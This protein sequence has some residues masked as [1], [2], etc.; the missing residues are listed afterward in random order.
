MDNEAELLQAGV[1]FR[2]NKRGEASARGE[3]NWNED[4]STEML[5]DHVDTP[6]PVTILDCKKK[7][8]N[9][10]DFMFPLTLC[11]WTVNEMNRYPERPR[12]PLGTCNS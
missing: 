12:C 3:F 6:G 2:D 10:F 4:L 7:E 1:M 8:I 11:I 9:F 5:V